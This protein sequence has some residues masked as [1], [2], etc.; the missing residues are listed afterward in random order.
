MTPLDMTAP[1]RGPRGRWAPGQSGNP[2]GKQPGTQNRATRLR[3]LLADGDDALAVQVLMDAVRAGDAVAARFVLDRLFPKP[4]D[5]DLDLGLPEGAGLAALF[6]RTVALMAAGE[7]TIDEASRIAKLIR[8]RR[9]VAPD[10]VPAMPEARVSPAFDLQTA[11]ADAA[12]DVA[13]SRP[14][15][16]HERRRAAAL[17]RAASPPEPLATA[18]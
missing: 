10:A 15:N 12:G 1:S 14:R 7:L 17:A 9:S 4:R 18:A 11:G 8:E 5:R 13:A 3:E 2:A 16:R 6:D